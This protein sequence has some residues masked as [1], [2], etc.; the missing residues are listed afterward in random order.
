MRDVKY[1]Q[2][3]SASAEQAFEKIADFKSFESHC[4]AVIAVDVTEINERESESTWLVHFH[5]GKMSW[6]ERDIFNK[7][8]LK[9][10]F[11]QI[12]G[13]AD[14]FEGVWVIE[15]VSDNEC[16]VTFDACFCMGI[17]T[18]A[19]ILEPIAESAIKQNVEQMLN[20]LFVSQQEAVA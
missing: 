19:D 7:E 3:V 17:P 11:T 14:I 18:L 13:D 2:T 6:R 15:S 16:T 9:I 10:E 20:E 1:T 4:Q 5:D 12:E 8:A